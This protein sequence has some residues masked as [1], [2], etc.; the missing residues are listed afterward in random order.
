MVGIPVVV[1]TLFITP[2]ALTSRTR[3]PNPSSLS[4]EGFV[5]AAPG[6]ATPAPGATA[7]PETAPPGH[8][9]AELESKPVESLTP[10]ELVELAEGRTAKRVDAARALRERM[11]QNPGLVQD[12]P[13]QTELLRLAN[14][15]ATAPTAL[16]TMALGAGPLSADL[17]Y[18]AWTGTTSKNDATELARSLVYSKDVR[19]RASGALAVALD[20]RDADKCED[21]KAILPRALKDG[22]RR[23]LHLLTKLVVKRGC[24]A[25]K[26][27]DCYACLRD[28]PQELVAIMNAVK[29]R[30]PPA[31]TP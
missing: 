22:D 11:R 4:E 14:D 2:L 15:T 17:L 12:K 8:S 25:K 27:E 1:A 20:L 24:G 18:E 30:K 7:A 29:A 26:T 6:A 16:G 19:S 9:L 13:T 5:P 23:S 31:F 3:A 10:T 28:D 21:F